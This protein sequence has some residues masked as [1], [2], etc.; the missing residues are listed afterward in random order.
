MFDWVRGLGKSVWIAIGIFFAA[1]AV[2]AATRNKATADKWREKAV[3]I[4]AGN[5]VRG[6]ETAKAA[7][8]QAKKFDAEADRFEAKGNAA[9]DRTGRKDEPT[10]DLLSRWKK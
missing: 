9:M 6:V 5:V 1:M 10:A 4:E 7:L 3:D 8:S 2:A